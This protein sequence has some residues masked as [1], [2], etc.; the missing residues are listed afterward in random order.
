MSLIDDL[1]PGITLDKAGYP[2]MEAAITK[3]V[4]VFPAHYVVED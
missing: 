2:D 4:S 3:N 1:F